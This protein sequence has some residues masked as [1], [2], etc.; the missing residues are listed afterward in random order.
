MRVLVDITSTS[1]GI[2]MADATTLNVGID[3]RKLL[4]RN[5]QLSYE[6]PSFFDSFLLPIHFTSINSLLVSI[7]V[8]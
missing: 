1:Q 7:V 4:R 3:K 5:M 6:C 8:V 2:R